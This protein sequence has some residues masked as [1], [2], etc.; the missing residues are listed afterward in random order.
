MNYSTLVSAVADY[1]HRDD[2]TAVIPTFIELAEERINRA[3]R[4][5]DMELALASTAITSNRITLASDI[6][7]VKTL[8]RPGYERTPLQA[9]SFETVLA[10]GTEGYPT[11]Y[12]RQGGDLYFDG[13]GDVQGVLYRRVPAL[14]SINTTNWLATKWP[15]VY[16]FGVL[17]E[18]DT[19]IKADPT[20]NEARFQVALNDVMQDDRRVSGP[21]VARS[22]WFL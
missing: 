15:S 18:A 16:L 20:A 22:K 4:V 14:T 8:W 2:L 21:L 12:A 6:A 11:M 19:Y 17:S 1:L 3:L 13:S 5:R 7:D 10:N 9:Q